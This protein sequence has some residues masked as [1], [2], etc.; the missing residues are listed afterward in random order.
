MKPGSQQHPCPLCGKPMVEAPKFPGLW[1]CPDFEHPINK[2]PPFSYLCTG[3][4]MKGAAAAALY[5]APEDA[6]K[7][8]LAATGKSAARNN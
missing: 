1:T 2:E 4:E 7:D 8:I 6:A 3:M 5:R